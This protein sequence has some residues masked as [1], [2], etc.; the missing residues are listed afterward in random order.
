MVAPLEWAAALLPS[1]PRV[2][3]VS[4]LLARDAIRIFSS[5]AV[6]RSIHTTNGA[7]DPVGN[8]DRSVPEI[9]AEEFVIDELNVEAAAPPAYS[10][11]WIVTVQPQSEYP[12][13]E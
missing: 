8:V 11:A 5:D 12:K 6:P 4:V 9:D 7:V 2:V 10:F 3:T 13:S 1:Y